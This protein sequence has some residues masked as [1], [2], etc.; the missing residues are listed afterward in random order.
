LYAAALVPGMRGHT[1][2]GHSVHQIPWSTFRSSS[3]GGFGQTNETPGA[4]V[5]VQHNTTRTYLILQTIKTLS[6]A[7]SYSVLSNSNCTVTVS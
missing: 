2:R 7:A 3:L 4:T 6:T 1:E 5:R